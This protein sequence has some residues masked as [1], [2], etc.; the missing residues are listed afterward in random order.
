MGWDGMEGREVL[1]PRA[2]TGIINDRIENLLQLGGGTGGKTR[3]QPFISIPSLC[4]LRSRRCSSWPRAVRRGGNKD[5]A[6]QEPVA[7]VGHPLGTSWCHWPDGAEEE[8]ICEDEA[9][10]HPTFGHTRTPTTHHP[11]SKTRTARTMKRRA[12]PAAELRQ[13]GDQAQDF[14]P[15]QHRHGDHCCS[16]SASWLREPGHQHHS[17]YN[18]GAAI[19]KAKQPN[20]KV[21]AL[22]GLLAR[23]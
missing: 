23:G 8:V 13:Q 18:S 3:I 19:S 9:E 17:P 5:H 12:R 6:L 4:S 1:A 22:L 21:G 11:Q 15:C 7:V 16:T 14:R 10:C 2:H 20:L